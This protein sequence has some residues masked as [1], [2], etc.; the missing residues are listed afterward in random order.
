MGYF[1]NGAAGSEYESKVCSR[2]VHQKVNDGGCAVW[3]A[4]LIYNYKD[5]HKP[6][7]D[8]LIPRSED[9][10]YNKICAMFHPWDENRC[11]DTPD[12]FSG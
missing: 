3:L 1:P 11:A 4:H 12:M 7:L 10:L 6:V 2:C 9:G 8:L 5:D